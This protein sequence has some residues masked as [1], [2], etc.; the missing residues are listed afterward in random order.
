MPELPEVETV[1]RSVEATVVGSTVVRAEATGLRTVRRTSGRAVEVGL[2]G[3]TFVAARRRGKYLL[4][5]L[6]NGN[7]VMVHLR[8][9]GRLLLTDPTAP[10]EP[11][12][13]V[14]IGLSSPSGPE[15]DLRFVDPRTFGEVVV[16]NPDDDLVPEISRLGLDPLVD[17]FTFQQFRSALGRR[18]RGLKATLL[19]QSVVA[20]IGNIYV[21]EI[22]HR[23]RLR[24]DRKVDALSLAQLRLLH[25]NTVEVI[26]EAVEAGG[27]TLSD[28]QY[29]DALGREGIFQTAHRVYDR[30]GQRCLTCGR[31]IIR[32][33]V[34]AGRS[35]HFCPVCQR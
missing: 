28:T 6:A 23:T 35:T 15:T 29:V 22:L 33:V 25:A 31:G 24:H 12:T 8:M 14:V 20:G 7:S 18:K 30:E 4:F 10:R 9:S 3:E 19:D 32:R 11:H 2:L 5:D 34:A 27:S 17:E 26:R 1:R 13:H 21:D 16:F